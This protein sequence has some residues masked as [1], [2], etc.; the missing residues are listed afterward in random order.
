MQRLREKK[1]YMLK[2]TLLTSVTLHV[3]AMLWNRTYFSRLR[4]TIKMAEADHDYLSP[5]LAPAIKPRLRPAPAS[6]H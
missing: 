6:Q 4:L 3:T 5:F 2:K 1:I